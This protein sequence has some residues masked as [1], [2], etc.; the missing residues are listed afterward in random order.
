MEAIP[1]LELYLE[2]YPA[3]GIS[4]GQNI[5]NNERKS[6]VSGNSVGQGS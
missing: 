6:L 3:R 4:Q 5:W 2:L 1:L